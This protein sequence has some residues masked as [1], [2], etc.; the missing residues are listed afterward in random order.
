MAGYLLRH[1]QLGLHWRTRQLQ[2]R[3]QHVGRRRRQL[4]LMH[5]AVL[6]L[7]LSLKPYSAHSNCSMSAQ[8]GADIPTWVGGL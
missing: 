6:A 7:L 8:S 1:G 3:M 2:Y 5:S 4:R